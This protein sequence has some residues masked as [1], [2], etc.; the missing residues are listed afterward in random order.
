LGFLGKASPS[1]PVLFFGL[2]IKSVLGLVVLVAGMATWPRF[3]ERHFVDAI[4][5]GERLLHLARS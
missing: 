5:V 4:A 1:L 2:S 3:F